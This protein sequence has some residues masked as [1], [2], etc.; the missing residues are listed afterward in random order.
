MTV[1]ICQPVVITFDQRNQVNLRSGFFQTFFQRF[2][3][4][5]NQ[6][7]KVSGAVRTPLHMIL[8]YDH[9]R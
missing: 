2:P 9:H 4:L 7:F 3:F 6:A 5:S 8:P 1:S